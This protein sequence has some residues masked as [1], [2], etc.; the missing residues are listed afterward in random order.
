MICIGASNSEGICQRLAEVDGRFTLAELAYIARTLR[1]G[2]EPYGAEWPEGS[3]ID[4]LSDKRSVLEEI[5][6][7][8]GDADAAIIVQRR[9]QRDGLE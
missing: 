2:P 7:E 6:L 3:E 4:R 8:S 5:A 9:R 1:E